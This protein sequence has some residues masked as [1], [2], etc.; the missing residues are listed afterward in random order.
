MDIDFGVIQA[1]LRELRGAPEKVEGVFGSQD[2]QFYTHPVL[3]PTAIRDFEQKHRIE[4]PMEYRGF[5]LRVGNGGAGPGYGVFRLEEM[6]DGFGHRAWSENDGCIGVLSM[7]FPHTT[8]W[9]DLP[10]GAAYE[11]PADDR[12][13]QEENDRYFDAVNVNGAI[14]ICHLGCALRQWL[15]V[16]GPEAGNIWNDDRAQYGGLSPLQQEGLVRVNFAQSHCSWLQDAL[17][18]LR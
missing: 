15:V 14:P 17:R 2:H 4:L 18:R 10:E 16:T 6:D 5:L 11:Y 9:N 12:G 1:A 13:W 3:S 8:S 7:P